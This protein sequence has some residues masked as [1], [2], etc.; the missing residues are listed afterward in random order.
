MSSAL[1][2]ELWLEEFRLELEIARCRRR[3]CPVD[4]VYFTMGDFE[5]R[6]KLSFVSSMFQLIIVLFTKIRSFERLLW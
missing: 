3:D 2:R 1:V 5:M 4:D 6:M